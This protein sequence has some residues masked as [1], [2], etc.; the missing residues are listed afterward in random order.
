MKDWLNN[1]D[2]FQSLLLG[3]L[4]MSIYHFVIIYCLVTVELDDIP[5]ILLKLIVVNALVR[6]I[7][8]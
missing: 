2:E 7:G 1:W 6:K 5:M 8:V 3:I 4:V